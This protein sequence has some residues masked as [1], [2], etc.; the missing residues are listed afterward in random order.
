MHEAI[1]PNPR[2][3]SGSSS[4]TKA[5]S[6]SSRTEYL[7]AREYSWRVSNLTPRIPGRRAPDA[8][9]RRRADVR[10]VHSFDLA[11]HGPELRRE[12]CVVAVSHRGAKR[13]TALALE[14]A[15]EKGCPTALITGEAGSVKGGRTPCSGRWRRRDRPPHRQLHDRRGPARASRRQAGYHGDRLGNVAL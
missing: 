1:W 8:G 10:A 15:R 9:L 11:L 13:Y 7:S 2:R 4:A 6:T 14:R 12:D 3:W 5:R